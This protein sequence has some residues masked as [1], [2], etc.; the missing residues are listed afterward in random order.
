[1]ASCECV[2]PPTPTFMG[3]FECFVPP[4]PT[5]VGDCEY[6]IPP[7][8]TCVGDVSSE[9]LR[10]VL[11]GWLEKKNMKTELDILSFSADLNSSQVI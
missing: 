7:T 10:Y 6:V 5:C 2:S 1:M 3:D 8:P 9:W 4:T 11:D